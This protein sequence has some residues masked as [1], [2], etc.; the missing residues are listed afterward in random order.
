M[1]K[2]WIDVSELTLILDQIV[3]VHTSDGRV[4]PA[5]VVQGLGDTLMLVEGQHGKV[6]GVT[7]WQP[8]PEPP[9][10]NP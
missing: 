4:F 6:D 1:S 3:I 8:L 7:H 5:T 10:P 2:E 9:T